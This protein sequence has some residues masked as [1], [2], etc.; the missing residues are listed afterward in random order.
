L[1]ASQLT[2]SSLRPVLMI[3]PPLMA[4]SRIEFITKPGSRVRTV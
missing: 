2:I 1:K 3:I 4:E